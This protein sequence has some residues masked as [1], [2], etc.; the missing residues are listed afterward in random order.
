[1]QPAPAPDQDQ[2]DQMHG[3]Q[4]AAMFGRI[5]G[6]YDFLNHTL[7]LGLDIYWR[8]R[9]ARAARPEPGGLA[10]DLA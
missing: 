4:V 9:L 2:R 7:S 5:A 8:W 1:M 10:L 3:R 6:W